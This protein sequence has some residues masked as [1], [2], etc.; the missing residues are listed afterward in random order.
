[1]KYAV[2]LPTG[3]ECGDPGLVVEL[4]GLAEESGFDGV[5]LEDY[6]FFQGDPTAPT[7]DPWSALAAIAVRT[8][9]ITMGTLVTAL[10][11]RRPWIVARQAAALDQLSDG[12]MVLGVGL[13]DTGEHVIDDVSF[14]RLGEATNP[15][16]RAERLDEALDI[17]AGL[18]TG[19]PFSHRGRHYTVDDLT[20]APTPQQRPRIPIWVGGGYPNPGPTRRAARWDGAC[21]YGTEQH[22]LQPVQVRALR[23]AAGDRT[24]DVCVGGR[25][26]RDGDREWL[27]AVAEAGAT[28]WAEYVPPGDPVDMRDRIRRGPLRID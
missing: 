10:A 21:M 26:R 25:P 4:A 20:F 13:G 12:R 8:E 19:R 15:A 9:R 27:S 18:W 17:I 7:T 24:Y 28:W 14:S 16:E 5:F 6:V 22:D 23:Q 1:M 11:R 3:A 2:A